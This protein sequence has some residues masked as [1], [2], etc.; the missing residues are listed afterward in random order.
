MIK[1]YIASPYT[2]GDVAVNVKRQIDMVDELMNLGFAP[3]APLYSHFQ[4]LIHPRPYE[5]WLDVDME[6]VKACDCVLR[7]FGKSSGAEKE[8]DLAIA[9]SKPVFWSVND[10]IDFYKQ[11]LE[12]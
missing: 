3:F 12:F 8:V 9:L 1:V 6:W 11:N 4:H 5:D 7:L 2:K 10:L